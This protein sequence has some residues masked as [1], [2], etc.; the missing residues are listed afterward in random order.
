V[1]QV[2]ADPGSVDDIVEGELVDERTGLHEEGQ[3]LVASSAHVAPVK[4]DSS[5]TWPMPPDA[6]AT[7]VFRLVFGA[8]RARQIPHLLLPC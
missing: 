1:R 6:P 8:F 3:R 5:S 7:T 4:I 2:N